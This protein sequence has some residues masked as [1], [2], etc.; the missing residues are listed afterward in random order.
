MSQKQKINTTAN[1]DSATTYQNKETELE[2]TAKMEA[3]A[4]TAMVE[5]VFRS[6]H[7]EHRTQGNN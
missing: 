3:G 5:R 1:I 7:R 2:S 4:I 6:D